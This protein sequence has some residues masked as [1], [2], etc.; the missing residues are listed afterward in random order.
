[1]AIGFLGGDTVEITEL[2]Q[3]M[4]KKKGASLEKTYAEPYIWI[5]NADDKVQYPK[6]G[7]LITYGFNPRA[8][9]TASSV[10]DGAVQICIQRG[11]QSLSRRSLEPQEFKAECPPETN[12]LS[13]MGA[14]TACAVC[15]LWF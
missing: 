6:H 10:A 9:V 5:V 14:V 1:V 7:Q 4:C 13:V 2:F 12:P 8:S 3:E 11:F 15:D